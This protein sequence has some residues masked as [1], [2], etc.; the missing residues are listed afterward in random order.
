MRR[1]V[2]PS[3]AERKAAMS[4]LFATHDYMTAYR[5]YT[6]W[7]VARDPHGAVGSQW[8][9]LGQLQIDYLICYGL[10]PYHRLL[11]FGCGTL[12][13]G[14]H[15]IRYLNPTCYTGIELSSAALDYARQLVERSGL[16]DK[17][18]SLILNQ[19]L[20]QIP[21]PSAKY[22]FVLAQSVFTHL[23][24]SEIEAV[25]QFVGTVMRDEAAFFFTFND[26]ARVERTTVKDF[27][28][29]F[30][31]FVELGAHMGFC[32]ERHAD[33]AHPKG[34]TMVLARRN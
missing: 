29:P 2:T 11:D 7:F 17:A 31:Y 6:D 13:A 1:L 4:E 23:Y 12:R 24:E 20:D 26:A 16:A 18:P 9:E 30:A 34:Q 33:Y 15:F 27:R 25:F 5:L 21:P 32:I 3:V 28:Y 19:G 14:R 8:E 22:D 10:K